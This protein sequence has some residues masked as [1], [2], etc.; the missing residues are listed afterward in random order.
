MSNKSSADRKRR[1]KRNERISNTPSNYTRPEK[2]GGGL[3]PG[4]RRRREYELKKMGL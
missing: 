1:E 2:I 3:Y 4:D